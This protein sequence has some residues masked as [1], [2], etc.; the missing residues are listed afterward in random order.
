[1]IGFVETTIGEG[2]G[3]EAEDTFTSSIRLYM[4]NNIP[5]LTYVGK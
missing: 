2:G 4:I 3:G 1:M 5:V